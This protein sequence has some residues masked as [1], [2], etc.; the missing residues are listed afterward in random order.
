MPGRTFSTSRK[1]D[2]KWFTYFHT[3]GRGPTRLISP[4]RTFISWGSSSTFIFLKALPSFVTLSS[5]STVMEGPVPDVSGVIERNLYILKGRRPFPILSCLKNTGPPSCIFIASADRHKSG[6][7]KTSPNNEN[8]ISNNLFRIPIVY[9]S[10]TRLS[11]CPS[12]QFV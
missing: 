12:R 8:T 11:R 2:M 9:Y 5:P 1:S 10:V 7:R 6:E 4:F 3:S